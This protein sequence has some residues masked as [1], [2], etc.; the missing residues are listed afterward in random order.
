MILPT[1]N[2]TQEN[3]LLGIGGL[4]LSQLAQPKSITKLWD[5]V[6]AKENIT[7]FENFILALDLLYLLEAIHMRNGRIYRG[8]N[9]K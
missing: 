2:I 5:R 1:K 9:D 8:N 6:K 3:S 4:L 7:S